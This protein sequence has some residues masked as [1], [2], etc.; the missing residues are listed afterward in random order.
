MI[1]DT[2]QTQQQLATQRDRITDLL[3][4]Q[5]NPSKMQQGLNLASS[6]LTA[7]SNNTGAAGVDQAYSQYEDQKSQAQSTLY[8][9]MQDQVKQGNE[10]ATYVDQ[11][12]KDFAGSDPKAYEA[13]AN[14]VH[15]MPE[16]IGRNNATMAVSRAANKLGIKSAAYKSEQLDTAYKQAQINK[17]NSEAQK[18]RMPNIVGNQGV[19]PVL[20]RQADKDIIL[21]TRESSSGA[22]D[23]LRSLDQIENA[24]FDKDGKPKANTGKGAAAA[25]Y[26][27]QIIPGIDSSTYQDVQSKATRLSLD[28]ASMLKGQTSDKDVARSLMTA[29]GYDKSPAANKKI[30][31]DQKAALKVVS[32]SPKFISKWRNKYGSTLGT[33]EEGRTFDEAYLDW[34]SSRFKEL[35]GQKESNISRNITKEDAIAELKRRGKM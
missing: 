20:A 33:D 14:E 21:K 15:N 9:L 3:T 32:E 5:A 27:G 2:S 12:I 18:A 34:Q 28:V 30:I 11:V 1:T 25:Q 22:N 7:L 24:L 6:F 4:K 16:P 13:I 17:L 23:S 35:G 19:D 29:P 10:D 8:Q 31:A 26:V